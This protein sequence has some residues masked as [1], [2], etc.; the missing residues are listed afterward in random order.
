MYGIDNVT[1]VL[2]VLFR[3][4]YNFAVLREVGLSAS[5][6]G[7][8]FRDEKNIAKQNSYQVRIRQDKSVIHDT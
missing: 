7:I 5:V 8:L 6:M 2:I 4:Y 3:P 1:T